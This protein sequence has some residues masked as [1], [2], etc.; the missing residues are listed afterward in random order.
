MVVAV[1]VFSSFTFISHL[2]EVTVGSTDGALN[3]VLVLS[4]FFFIL[5]YVLSVSP[6]KNCYRK[7]TTPSKYT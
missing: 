4:F 5:I 2:A 7:V 3:N 6:V 1:I